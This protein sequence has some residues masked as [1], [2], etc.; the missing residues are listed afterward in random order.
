M[1]KEQQSAMDRVEG[2]GDTVMVDD[3]DI[4]AGLVRELQAEF[5]EKLSHYCDGTWQPPCNWE[6]RIKRMAREIEDGLGEW[7]KQQKKIKTMEALANLEKARA[8][9]AEK[10]LSQ[11]RQE[12]EPR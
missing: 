11:A 8:E 5:E 3:M 6:S 10:E 7:H 2:N 1:T 9:K 4:I 12:Q